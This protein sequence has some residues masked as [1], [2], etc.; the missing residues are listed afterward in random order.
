VE[1]AMAGVKKKNQMYEHI[2]QED[3][4]YNPSKWRV[5]QIKS[6]V[7]RSSTVLEQDMQNSDLFGPLSY[8]C[9][10]NW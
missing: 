1:R 3:T 4:G 2:I 8:N 6:I 5:N 7:I 9:E 10:V